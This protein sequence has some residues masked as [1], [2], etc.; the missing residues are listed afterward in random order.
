MNFTR[1]GRRRPCNCALLPSPNI[2][3]ASTRLN[4]ATAKRRAT[5]AV[6]NRHAALAV[7][8]AAVGNSD[9]QRDDSAPRPSAIAAAAG[10][11]A[12]VALPW[13][14]P[15]TVVL[16]MLAPTS[17]VWFDAPCWGPGLSVI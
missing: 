15:L 13:V 14:C 2:R 8:A 11:A 12:A 1:L 9:S 17:F 10:K 5:A 7:R 4:L 16:A 6:N 3:A